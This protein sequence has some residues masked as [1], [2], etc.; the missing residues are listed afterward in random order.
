VFTGTLLSFSVP[1]IPSGSLLLF[2]PVLPSYGIPAEAIG[3]LIAVDTVPDMFKTLLSVQGHITTVCVVDRFSRVEEPS[4][5][6][7]VG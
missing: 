7:A 3:V 2:A 5:Q 6:P 1:G 4:A